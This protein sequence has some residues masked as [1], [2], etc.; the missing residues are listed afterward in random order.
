MKSIITIGVLLL[1]VN[2]T[3][4]Q[5]NENFIQYDLDSILQKY[6]A[7]A[8]LVGSSLSL[9]DLKG[10]TIFSNYGYS[11]LQRK[12]T[13]QANT[14]F[15]IGSCSK[16][17]TAIAVLQLVEKGKI[18]LNEP[19][20]TYLPYLNWK[21]PAS[22]PAITVHHLLT[23]TAG[24]R[25]EVSN[26]LF[27][28]RSFSTCMREDMINDTLF[29]APNTLWAYSNYS[30]GILGCLIE[31]VSGLSY[32]SYL[33][34]HIFKPI[35][36]EN[37]DLYLEKAGDRMFA[38]GYDEE[39]KIYQ[40]GAVREP[41]VGD[42]VSCAKDMELFV[43]MLLGHGQIDGRQILKPE[44]FEMMTTNQ[45]APL[46]LDTGNE[47]GYGVF[48]S[49]LETVSDSL[50]GKIIAHKGDTKVFHAIFLV[51]PKMGVGVT[52]STNS[53]NGGAAVNTIASAV[54]MYYLEKVKNVDLADGS[55]NGFYEPQMQY[56]KLSN[57]KLIGQYDI[58]SG[59]L[60][61]K[62]KG[63]KKLKMKTDFKSPDIVLLP[64]DDGI[65]EA[66]V[67]LFKFLPIKVKST[68]VFFEEVEGE[69]Y[70]KQISKRNKSSDYIGKKIPPLPF[71]KDW[72][73][74]VGEYEIVNLDKATISLIPKSLRIHDGL[75]YLEMTAVNDTEIYQERSFEPQSSTFARSN[76]IGRGSGQ[77]L[78]VLS[79]GNLYY[80]G[81]EMK[82]KK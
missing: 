37:T 24:V 79:N 68:R 31:E 17:F 27:T 26:G 15:R 14:L 61:L 44:T 56:S 78:K 62:K 21:K 75:I 53:E 48:I 70:M 80:S 22:M 39:Q 77:Y 76:M 12:D 2:M 1:M 34:Q 32:Q 4:A 55:H 65:F 63:K 42:L 3:K 13:V 59:L 30:Y 36:M 9:T 41:A 72:Q 49:E 8:K 64:L 10:E 33:S 38:A 71:N 81:F 16:T 28:E 57:E 45:L 73:N 54:L 43:R 23:H 74:R 29:I 18:N 7:A 46:K 69:I 51:L 52:V 6:A 47:F 5:G 40:E 19:I 50:L 60:Y 35:G 25:D 20:Q 66:K 58:G 82:I 11:N 67:F